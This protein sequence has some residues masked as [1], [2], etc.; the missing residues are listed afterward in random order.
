MMCIVTCGYN[1]LSSVECQYISVGQLNCTYQ[2]MLKELFG[3]SLK[4]VV[5]C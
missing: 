3:V 5:P 2:W 4:F 1:D